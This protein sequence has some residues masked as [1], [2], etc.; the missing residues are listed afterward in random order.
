MRTRWRQEREHDE[1]FWNVCG[2][3][4]SGAG[5]GDDVAVCGGDVCGCVDCETYASAWMAA[6]YDRAGARAADAGDAGCAGKVSAG[7]E[8]RV[9]AA[10]C[11]AIAAGWSCHAVDG[12]GGE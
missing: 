5:A 10:D 8:G 9:S 11:D 4:V 1:H 12:S 6:L 2:Q 3:A 7:G